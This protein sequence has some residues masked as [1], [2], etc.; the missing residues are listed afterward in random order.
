[1]HFPAPSGREGFLS[2]WAG[3]LHGG[4]CGWPENEGRERGPGCKRSQCAGNALPM[5]CRVAF[6]CARC[7]RTGENCASR[8]HVYSEI[9]SVLCTD[10]SRSEPVWL[11]EYRTLLSGI[12]LTV[13]HCVGEQPPWEQHLSGGGAAEHSLVTGHRRQPGKVTLAV[14]LETGAISAPLNNYIKYSYH[15]HLVS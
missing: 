15:C 7:I 4:R 2:L 5:R 9:R 1:M 11:R 8:T 13:A 10:F 14:T 3:P 12:F 6:K